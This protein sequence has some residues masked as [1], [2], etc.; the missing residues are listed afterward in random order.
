MCANPM[1]K[2]TRPR[3][4]RRYGE[5]WARS[6][7]EEHSP[8]PLQA[9]GLAACSCTDLYTRHFHTPLTGFWSTALLQ[10]N[11]DGAKVVIC[12]VG[13]LLTGREEN[14]Q[15]T[16]LRQQGQV[17]SRLKY[18]HFLDPMPATCHHAHS[19]TRTFEVYLEPGS[20]SALIS[21]TLLEAH[22]L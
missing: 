17:Y 20:S 18:R 10:H 11:A 6:W 2:R 3:S 1:L 4:R 22:T 7:R 5:G 19:G 9:Q 12:L 16:D 8:R 15:V 21:L 14:R 13:K